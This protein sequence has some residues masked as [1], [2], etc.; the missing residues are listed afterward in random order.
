M[1]PPGQAT[2]PAAPAVLGPAG[3]AGRRPSR[4]PSAVRGLL[5]SHPPVLTSVHDTITPVPPKVREVIAALEADGW[6]QIA[7]AGSHR[8]FKHPSK[9]GR[10]TVAGNLGKDVPPGTLASIRHQAGL[11]K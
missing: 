5:A 2:I 10:V 1:A 8:H 3:S 4:A 7:Q 11:G 6:R 9:P